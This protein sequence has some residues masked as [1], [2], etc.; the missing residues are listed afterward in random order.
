M[1]RYIVDIV[2]GVT[3]NVFINMIN[4]YKIV[5]LR[6]L[7][8]KISYLWSVVELEYPKHFSD[9]KM[10]VHYQG[11]EKFRTFRIMLLQRYVALM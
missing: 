8:S 7:K 3:I 4:S 5:S 1:P 10:S 6:A 11:L 2:L 9:I